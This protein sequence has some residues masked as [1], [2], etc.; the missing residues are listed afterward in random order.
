MR[1]LLSVIGVLAVALGLM[2]TVGSG[3]A[4]ASSDGPTL[5]WPSD[6]GACV[7]FESSGDKIYVS[8]VDADGHSAVAQ[9]CAPSNCS[10][11]SDNLWQHYGAD[12]VYHWDYGTAIPEGTTVYYRPCIGEWNGG[13]GGAE[14]PAIISCNSGWAHGTA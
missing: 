14:E 2:F 7:W 1:R 9:V 4:F 6:P 8:D 11:I 5:C 12:L 13:P 3:A 10:I